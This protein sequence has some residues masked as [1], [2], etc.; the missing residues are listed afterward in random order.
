[1]HMH[2]I[3]FDIPYPAN[4]GGAIDVYYKVRALAQAG[5]RVHLHC[6]EYGKAHSAELSRICESVHYYL[7]LPPLLALPVSRPYIVASRKSAQLL[8]RVAAMS[9]PVVF[10][11]LHSCYYLDHPKL[12]THKKLVRTHN[13][14]GD[15]YEQLAR[16]EKHWGRRLYYQREA[17]LLRAYEPVLAH[18]D[19]LLTISPK[20]Q[21]YFASRYKNVT[22]LPAFHPHEKLSI[23]TGKGEYCLYHGKLSVAENHRAA[24]FLIREVFKHLDIP[25]IIAGADPLPELITE[26]SRYAHITLRHNVGEGEMLDLMRNAHVHVLPAFQDTGIKLKLLNALFT[27]RFCITHPAMVRQT[28]LEEACFVA[29]SATDFNS[30]ISQLMQQPFSE[31]EIDRR[32]AIL[33]PRFSNEA[34]ADLL[35]K[36]ISAP[37]RLALNAAGD[38]V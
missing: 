31:A 4:Y 2:L 17:R 23:R 18:A 13:V 24:M 29:R 20:D 25:L 28:G 7:R 27:G 3:S 30:L 5:V 38:P 26:I 32:K 22:Y 6:Y 19:H 33:L 10:E 12:A 36:L 34:N 15:Y 16:H 11:G 21:Q 8:D 9:L 37:G 35:I 14:E 1:M